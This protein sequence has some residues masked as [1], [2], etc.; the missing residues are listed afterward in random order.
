[1]KSRTQK[2]LVL[3]LALVMTL[4]LMTA[5]G[6]QETKEPE[7]PEEQ[8]EDKPAADD[9]QIT[10]QFLHKW[11][12]P[13]Y[14]FF[15]E[16]VV[17]KFMAENPNI[18]VEMEAVGDEPIKD[19]L[20]IVMG[21]QEQPDVFFSWSGEFAK[22]FVRSG[23]SLDL[24]PYLEADPE[25]RDSFMMAG[26]EPFMNDGKY[27]GIP[28]RI[29]GKFFVYNKQ[30]FADNGVEEPKTWEEFMNVCQT[31]KDNGVTPI[32]LGNIYP[33]AGCHYITG[34]NQK[35]VPQEVREKDYLASQG[36][37]TDPGYVRALNYFK[38]IADRG[39][40]QEGVNSTEH[41]MSLEMFYGGQVAMVYVEL[42][43][44]Q[45]V[46]DKMAGNWGFFAMPAIEG[47]PGNQNFLVGAPD[48][49]MVSAHS[50]H[51]DEAVK[52]LQYLT[53]EA[54][55]LAMVENLHWPSPVKGAVNS[56]NSMEML[57]EGLNAVAEA[58]G[59]ALWLDTDI[60]IRISDVYL[61]AL[62]ELLN[63]DKTA[64][65]VMAEVQQIA[66]TVK[67]ESK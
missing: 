24:T 67:A 53:N 10:I 28:Y 17:E 54:N 3:L 59:M 19:K 49:F 32:G 51:P 16:E 23:N 34:L 2:V 45:D 65:E 7:K 12:N 41:N 36:E 55:S 64:E 18:K 57:V 1:M 63:G 62:Q 6:G 37:Y 26:L 13:E 47:E 9:E 29:N 33:W 39:F 5:C 8:A 4:S 52:F 48:G 25:W 22:N 40:F 61:P 43:E 66:E 31:L 60:D 20:R 15:F 30:I 44:F 14:N 11:P 46:E 42:E 21:T 38:E 56:D 50:Q 27:Y 58:E 35:C